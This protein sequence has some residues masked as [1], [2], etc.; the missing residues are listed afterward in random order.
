MRILLAHNRYQHK[1]GEDSVF[2][3]EGNLLRENGHEV[4]EYTKS[5]DSIKQH[6]SI[7]VAIDAIWSNQSY[8]ELR[9]TFRDSK[10]DVV[11]VHNYTPQISP[12]IFHAAHAEKI[13]IVQT[14]HNFR[15]V[16]VAGML[17]RNG[18]ICEKCVEKRVKWP[19]V[20]HGC[21]R[22]S[23]LAS[24]T[25]AS[26]LSI[27]H[28]LGTWHNKVTRYIT[29]TDFQR[30]KLI[31]AGYPAERLV[32]KPN[33]CPDSELIAA[34][35]ADRSRGMFV[36]RLS[37]E[38]GID[39]LV[40]AA[41]KCSTPIDL[42]GSGPKLEAVQAAAPDNLHVHGYVNDDDMRRIQETAL[43]LVLPSIV[44]EGFP[45]VIPEA[46]SMGIPIIASRHGGMQ[47][48]IDDGVTGLHF[49]PGDANDLAEKIK[50]ASDNPDKMREF[51][52][53]ARHVYKTKFS[54]TQNLDILTGIY[55]DAIEEVAPGR[56][57]AIA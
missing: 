28:A 38:K 6:G 21:Y 53:T 3:A 49:T 7:R 8:K 41:R 57:R 2:L 13:P 34:S 17:M 52:R 47:E 20:M 50:W 35:N 44:Y 56:A 33:F 5:N 36:G 16:C 19:G 9:K 14:L 11:H 48:I 15:M 27:H 32:V 51:G 10:P 1:G 45:M 29:L 30:N 23:R 22:N 24:A 55:R 54:P 25:V 4:L 18:A 42:V 37:N 40:D 31:A 43:F 26:M 12:A 46:F 39:V